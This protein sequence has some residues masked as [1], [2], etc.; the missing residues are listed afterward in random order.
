MSKFKEMLPLIR[1]ARKVLEGN[2]HRTPLTFSTY[3]SN[4]INKN[5]Y[6]K[7]ENL[8]KTGSFKVRGAL[9]KISSLLPE[10]KKKGVIAASSGNHAQGVAYSA[11]KL[12]VSA[13]IVMPETAPP[14]KV[15]AT[16]SYGAKVILKGSVYDDAY[17]EAVRLSKESGAYFIHPFDDPYVIAGQGTIGLEISEDLPSVDTVLV[18]VGGGGIISGIAIGVKELLQARKIKV[19]GVEPEGD[20]KLKKALTLGKPVEVAPKPSLADG[21]LTKSIG[22]LTFQIIR[23]Y[24]DD[25]LEVDEDEIARAMYLLLERSK[26]LAEG[27]GALPLAA[28]LKHG[29]EIPGNNIVAVISGGNADLTTLYKVILRGLSAEGRLA[30]IAL[31]LKDRPGTLKQALDYVASAGCNIIEIRHDRFGPGISPGYANVELLVET[32]S[33]TAINEM[34]SKLK[35]AR[36]KVIRHV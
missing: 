35:Q 10:A 7:L 34:L 13:T 3:F 16:R 24:V 36:V 9:F 21:V 27:A 23:E 33:K 15:N 20:P 31:E 30:K 32:P 11:S 12:G 4:L 1:E 18:P 28:I 19:I 26:L 6:L 25:V 17:V 14:Y 5:V 29:K 22:R 2:V 8:Q